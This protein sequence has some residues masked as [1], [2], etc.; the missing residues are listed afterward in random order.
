[1]SEMK[2]IKQDL[3]SVAEHMLGLTKYASGVE[4]K[5]VAAVKAEIETVRSDMEKM[6]DDKIAAL[7]TEIVGDVDDNASR[8]VADVGDAVAALGSGDT[9][10]STTAATSSTASPVT[11]PTI[12]NP[13][14]TTTVAVVPAAASEAAVVTTPIGDVT[15]QPGTTVHVD[16]ATMP[17]DPAVTTVPHDGSDATAT[18]ASGTDVTP[19]PVTVAA[20]KVATADAGV[21]IPA[22]S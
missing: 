18:T 4:D 5:A 13:T 17:S 22:A 15:V 2:T 9:S 11:T 1:M 12:T 21:T 3:E 10:S 8:A 20:V 7:K 14:P 16:A 6:I 19:D